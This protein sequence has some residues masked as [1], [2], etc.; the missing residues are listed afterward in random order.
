MEAKTALNQ[1]VKECK[2]RSSVDAVTILENIQ[3][4]LREYKSG[5][6]LPTKEQILHGMLPFLRLMK[7]TAD[8]RP[9]C[10]Y[11][12]DLLRCY[13]ISLGEK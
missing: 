2:K 12:L 5:K 9:L 11:V 1:I 6:V 13:S 3:E 7:E 4:I 8:P 10:R